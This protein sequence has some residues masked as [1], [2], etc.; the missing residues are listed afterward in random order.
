MLESTFTVGSLL[1]LFALG[2]TA[3]N[4]N[5]KT[6]LSTYPSISVRYD[7]GD[8]I[9]VTSPKHLTAKV[10]LS[11]VEKYGI[12]TKEIQDPISQILFEGRELAPALVVLTGR[13]EIKNWVREIRIARKPRHAA[14]TVCKFIAHPNEPAGREGSPPWLFKPGQTVDVRQN[15]IAIECSMYFLPDRFGSELQEWINPDTTTT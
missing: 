8:P 14:S 10:E 1:S 2:A 7:T 15:I 3:V 9:G 11:S 6:G 13:T 5:P 4:F 12:S